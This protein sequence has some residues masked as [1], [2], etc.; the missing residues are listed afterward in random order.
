MP[1][2][3]QGN[4]DRVG[5]EMNRKI[6][7]ILDTYDDPALDLGFTSPLSAERIKAMTMKKIDNK[8]FSRKRIL[9]RV[10][11]AAAMIA[12]FSLTVLAYGNAAGWFRDFFGQMTD[13]ELSD[14]QIAFIESNSE[15]LNRSQTIEGYTVTLDS[16]VTDGSAAYLKTVIQ[17]PEGAN[18]PAQ[19]YSFGEMNAELP[20]GTPACGLIYWDLEETDA[21]QGTATYMLT[22][23]YIELI[24]QPGA[25]T[26]ITVELT[27]LYAGAKWIPGSW[28]FEIELRDDSVE[29][30]SEPVSGVTARSDDGTLIDITVTSARLR[31]MGLRIIYHPTEEPRNIRCYAGA[32]KAVLLD[33]TTVDL[34]PGGFGR[35]SDDADSD[36]WAEYSVGILPLEDIKY[37]ELPG[38]KQIAVNP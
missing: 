20:D 23:D 32:A 18:I 14:G 37:I 34:I 3:T 22:L 26:P 19:G 1:H 24:G 11:A 9:F 33:G 25:A 17:A 12:A 30:L 28:V 13:E 27:D 35:V 29:L 16:W 31:P 2:E 8:S 38:G 5:C 10:L 4:S 36:K 6:S 21:E 15:S 7:D